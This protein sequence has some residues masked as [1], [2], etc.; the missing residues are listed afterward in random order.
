MDTPRAVLVVGHGTISELKDVPE[1]L[2]RIR[3]GRP[4]PPELVGEIQRRYAKIGQS[5]LLDVTQSLVRAL[6]SRLSFPVRVA[7]RFWNP[8]VE[9][10]LREI[11]S[12]GVRDLCILPVAP[13]SVHVYAGVVAEA[14]SALVSSA[15]KPNLLPV[16]PY[17]TDPA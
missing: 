12:L 16:A 17:G 1:F 9:D 5:P 6:E 4:A 11:L 15:E 7:M 13:F 14:L 10:V 2:L 3:R 8:L